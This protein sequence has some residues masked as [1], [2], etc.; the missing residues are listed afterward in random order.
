M[1]ESE[2]FG[3]LVREL[4]PVERKALLEKLTPKKAVQAEPLIRKEPEEDYDLEKEYYSLGLMTR[5][6]IFLKV[7]FTGDD[8]YQLTEDLMLK[9]IEREIK[10]DGGDL[11]SYK[12]GKLHSDFLEEIEELHKAADFFSVYI[13]PAW[14]SNRD[15][16]LNYLGSFQIPIIHKQLEQ[17]VDFSE[18]EKQSG[19]VSPSDLRKEVILNVETGLAKIT[20]DLRKSMYLYSKTFSVMNEFV[21]FDF[22]GFREMFSGKKDE[23]P[24][25]YFGDARVPLERLTDILSAFSVSPDQ[26]LLEAL[27]LFTHDDLEVK[28]EDYL[29][30]ELEKYLQDAKDNLRI[31]RK[32][33]RR[34]RPIR[35]MKLITGNIGYQP[36]NVSGGEDWFNIYSK[37]WL[38]LA[39]TRYRKYSAKKR[40][41]KIY[42]DMQMY[43]KK[44]EMPVLEFFR[45]AFKYSCGF[46]HVFIRDELAAG[47]NDVLKTILVDGR[48]YKKQNKDDFTDSYS[49]LLGLYEKLNKL[50][51]KC[52]PGGE[53]RGQIDEA[54]REMVSESVR[55]K[56][57]AAINEQ[58][59]FDAHEILKTGLESLLLLKNIL[60][61]ILHGKAGGQY[62]SLSNLN[63][64]VT[65]ESR[66]FIIELNRV[67]SKVDDAYRI[68]G[69]IEALEETD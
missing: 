43:F 49:R 69:D 8:K 46:L 60:Y 31:V 18:T 34:I 47:M 37:Y 2:V 35:L 10:R 53:Y 22:T 11:V 17:V 42:K 65:I 7:M 16:F 68:L 51:Q 58:I 15:E 48:F 20:G 28:E 52:A 55:E 57:I 14:K 59:D 21:S 62:D 32:F 4:D 23:E 56:H 36:R 33:N 3:K 1:G 24:S 67:Y 61:G 63:K 30:K 5:L 26:N 12:E 64:L 29:K 38:N 44:D 50:D 27:Y 13:K 40:R 41:E 54:G 39:E 6:V 25:C 9:K 66:D 45:G 19:T